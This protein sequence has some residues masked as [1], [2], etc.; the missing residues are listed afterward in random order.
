MKFEL[1]VFVLLIVWG[2]TVKKMTVGWR[3]ALVLFVGLWIYYSY[4]K[5]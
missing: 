2:L 5:G 1:P 3:Y 4:W